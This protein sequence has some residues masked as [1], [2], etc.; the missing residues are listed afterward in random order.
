[1]GK[2]CYV[3]N[4]TGTYKFVEVG[5]SINTQSLAIRWMNTEKPF[6]NFVKDTILIINAG[7]L[8]K[9]GKDSVLVELGDFKQ[10]Q[11]IC[12]YKDMMKILVDKLGIL[13]SFKEEPIMVITDI[14]T[15]EVLLDQKKEVVPAE[16][17]EVPEVATSAVI[18]N[19]D[20]YHHVYNVELDPA[21]DVAHTSATM[22]VP[23]TATNIA[24]PLDPIPG[25][26]YYH[27]SAAETLIRSMVNELIDNLSKIEDEIA[28]NN[29]KIEELE[30]ANERNCDK[31]ELYKLMIKRL[32]A[33]ISDIDGEKALSSAADSKPM[34][35]IY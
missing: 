18:S 14:V 15:D 22:T 31:G 28:A 32:Q 25:L 11:I 13:V 10:R 19:S 6:G 21:S 17:K 29:R 20:K 9:N 24:T 27:N 16:V 23:K 35:F 4:T 8:L 1:M 3:T 26:S 5:D 33:G 30:R 2:A 7:W 34:T 12:S